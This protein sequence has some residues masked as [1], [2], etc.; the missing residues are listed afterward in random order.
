MEDMADKKITRLIAEARK[1]PGWR[2]EDT[3]KGWMLYPPDKTQSGVLIHGTP[4][5][6]RAW[7]NTVSLLCK[8]GAPV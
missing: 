2:V 3:R 5:D 4:G 6:R 1:W 7:A 8:R